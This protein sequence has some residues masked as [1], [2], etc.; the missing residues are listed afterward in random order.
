MSEPDIGMLEARVQRDAN[1][2]GLAAARRG[3]VL[4]LSLSYVLLFPYSAADLD[5]SRDVRIA[6]DIVDGAAFPLHGPIL[7]GSINLGPLW[8][9]FL[10]LPL[11]LGL[12][13][14]GTTVLVALVAM[15]QIP[16]AYLAGK[17]WAGRT[18]GLIWAGLLLLPSWSMFEQVFNGHQVLTGLTVTSM[19]LFAIRFLSRATTG[20]FLGMTLAF[21]LA[22][23]AH[24]TT[25]PLGILP[26]ICLW[27]G[28]SRRLLPW[29]GVL[30]AAAVALL[31]FA[32][33][34]IEQW[35]YGWTIF[36]SVSGY[37]S[38]DQAQGALRN[39]LPLLWQLSGGGLLYWT[40]T[41]AEWGD[42]VAILLSATN[43]GLCVAGMAGAI[44]R[45]L[46]GDRTTILLMATLIIA[47]MGVA[48][49]RAYYPYYFITGLRVLYLGLVAV[50]LSE[51]AKQGQRC[52][53]FGSA[54]AASAL[55]VYWFIASPYIAHQRNGSLPFA[56]NPMFNI[57]GERQATRPH[58]FLKTI[59]IGP[60]GEWLC[61]N[62]HVNIHGS[63]GQA[64]L[65]TYALGARLSCNHRQVMVGSGASD[66]EH[67]IGISH[68]QLN[69]IGCD[70]PVTIGGFGLVPVANVL[71]EGETV[72]LPGK[73]RYPPLPARFGNNSAL[74]L[75]VDMAHGEHIA[76]THIS[77]GMSR[78]PVIHVRC[79]DRKISPAIS[80][81]ISHIYSASGCDEVVSM[82]LA[83]P[84]LD[85]LDIVVF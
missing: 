9:Y 55:A 68:M 40:Q 5:Y 42:T 65:L 1:D 2:V 27:V 49:I 7:A 83:S 10:A 52:E 53:V 16:L 21:S 30:L 6:S 54:V 67:W 63:Y 60:S 22:L 23:H 64:L 26:L 71:S 66:G 34:L 44:K 81:N 74:S 29:S 78:E 59:D 18:T 32:P 15:G 13:Y 62:K 48:M 19:L 69:E 17:A 20:D 45:C 46:R 37:L 24:P 70:P 35:L 3:L 28:R 51:F 4:L 25:M 76:V 50:G 85:H 75:K 14:L 82:E 33:L 58:A 41:V 84:D 38:S 47:V 79:G 72:V 12:G 56:F 57:V 39:A 31:P 11:A 36:D 43:F 61:E 73:V 77:F 8:Y 80:D